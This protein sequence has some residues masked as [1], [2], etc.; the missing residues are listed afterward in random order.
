MYSSLLAGAMHMIAQH[1]ILRGVRGFCGPSV[2]EFSFGLPQNLLQC[3][4]VL[5]LD[6]VVLIL[7]MA[8]IHPDGCGVLK[9]CFYR[10]VSIVGLSRL[11][12]LLCFTMLIS[13]NRQSRLNNNTYDI[14][15]RKPLY[16]HN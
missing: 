10:N 8:L 11:C 4:H 6:S 16:L 5:F 1:I 15:A 14:S 12:S 3:V 7:L 9:H 2:R 13:S